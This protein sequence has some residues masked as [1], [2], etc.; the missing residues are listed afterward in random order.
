MSSLR[1]F[2]AW[3]GEAVNNMVPGSEDHPYSLFGS[4]LGWRIKSYDLTTLDCLSLLIESEQACP[5]AIHFGFAFGYDVNMILKDL[6]LLQLK[7]LKRLTRTRYKGFDIEYVPRKWLRVG[8]GRKPGRTTLRVFDVFSFFGKGLAPVLREYAIGTPEQID[9]ID[10]GKGERPNF[11]YEDITTSIEPYWETELVLMVDLMDRFR[12]ILHGAGIFI[13]SW[14]G[15]GAIA[16]YL[17]RQHNI[18]LHMDKG[19][20]E[21][22]LDAARYAYFGGRFEP[23]VAG[24]YDGPIYS[25]DINSAYP[26]SHSRMPSLANGKWVPELGRPEKNPSDIRLGLYRIKY[27][28]PYSARPMPLPHRDKSGSVSFSNATEGWFHAPEAG[29]VFNDP[30]AEFLESWVFEDD[31]SYPFDWINELYIKR[32]ELKANGDPTQIAFKLGPNSLYGQVAQ[33]AGWEHVDGPPKWHQLEWAGSITSECRSM[34]YAV[35]RSAGKALVSVDTDGVLSL[36]PFQYLPNGDGNA[37]GQ[38]KVTEYTG[39][40]YIQNGIYWLRDS[41]GQWLPPKTR[42]IPRKK[43]AFDTIFPVVARGED[44]CVSQHSFIGYG[45][46]LRGRM[47]EWRHWVD[48]PRTISFGGTGKRIHTVRSCPACK[49]G[50][51]RAEGLHM[52]IPVPGKGGIHSFPHYLPWFGPKGYESTDGRNYGA[53][54]N[55]GWPDLGIGRTD[56]ARQ[57]LMEQERWGIYE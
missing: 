7:N 26:Y 27:Q 34:V 17:L 43:L 8:Y 14:H 13:N 50:L 6:P 1:P 38:W 30:M 45:T 36:A 37:L 21:R 18:Q 5:E 3:D 54:D 48:A 49:K 35:A 2:V 47:D 23:F 53:D 57:E 4:S 25:A 31:G 29:L 9:R 11:L 20:P 28:A 51:G 33:R 16:S 24:Y 39:L 46:A 22:I 41:E 52:L 15:P 12:E 56:E 40:F 32:L 44:I 10:S 19:S 55:M 42:G